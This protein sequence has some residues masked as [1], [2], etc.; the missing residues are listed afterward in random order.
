M[1]S[2][3]TLKDVAARAGVSYQTVSKVLNRQ[4][5]VAPETEALIWQVVAALDYRPNIAARTLRKSASYLIGYSWTPQPPDRANPILDQF[6]TSTVEAAAVAGY[7]LLL[8]P[9]HNVVDQTQIYRNLVHSSRVDGFIVTGTNYDDPRIPL[10]QELNFPFVAFG[11]ANPE[12]RFAYVDVD[13][14]A[15]IGA[16]TQHLI[17]QGHH[18]IG[19]L[20]W[21]EGSR[22]GTARQNGYFEAMTK[23]GLVVDPCW[24]M[25]GSGDFETGVRCAHRLLQLPEA[26]RPTALVAVDDNLAMGAMSAAHQS[27]LRVGQEFGVTGFDDT[28]GIQ[29][30]TPSLTSVRQPT[31]QVGQMIVELLVDLIQGRTPANAQINLPPRLI[32]RQSSVRNS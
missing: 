16:A 5:N 29:H 21:P 10:L 20:A 8:F 9:S 17:D 23:A 30:L 1:T 32:V 18:R 3:V 13:G 6:L 19:L 24:I 27:G 14:R 22:V 4:A 26:Q 25:R 15:G 12:W 7:H 2:R 11:R 31:W 28:P